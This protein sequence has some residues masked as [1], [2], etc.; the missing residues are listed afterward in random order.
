MLVKINR[1]NEAENRV[2]VTLLDID[3]LGSVI[4]VKEFDLN[5]L[6]NDESIVTMLK[7][8]VHAII[9]TENFDNGIGST[10]ISAINLTDDELNQEKEK[11]IKAA[12][13]KIKKSK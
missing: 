8:S 7:T 10:I 1:I 6:S 9:F 12:N 4:P 3:D 11:M 2:N 5:I 13:D